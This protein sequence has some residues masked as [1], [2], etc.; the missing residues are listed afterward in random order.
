MRSRLL[1][2]L[3]CLLVATVAGV[4]AQDVGD[5]PSFGD[6]RLEEGFLPDPET[7]TVK[8][9]NN[10]DVDVGSCSYGYVSEAPDIDLYYTTSGDSPLYIYVEGDGDTMLLV[11]APNGDWECNDDGHGDLNPILS[12]PD[13]QDGL[14]N[15]WVGSYGDQSQTAMLYVSE[16][17]PDGGTSS[18][19]S[20][21]PDISL[22]P[23]YGDVSLDAGFRPDPHIVSLRAG[24]SLEVDVGSCTYGY[25]ADAPDVDFY[26]DANNTAQ[27]YFYVES[28]DDTTLLI[29][30]PDGSWVCD[31]DGHEGLN[32]LVHLAKPAGGLYNIWV[33]T[34]G[35]DLSDA[36]LF[37]SEIDPS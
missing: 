27:L 25:V 4:G 21:A 17:D 9:G 10:V 19:E 1:P 36:Q 14:Y 20:G 2:F 18:G 29:N 8:T 26:Y 30:R 12:F 37:I 31:D 3:V 35:D 7:V 16:I 23:T 24:G 32:P 33:G 34:Y 13:A 11:N 5:P 6:L 28:D 22:D 15:I